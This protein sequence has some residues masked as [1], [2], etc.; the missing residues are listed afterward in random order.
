MEAISSVV[1]KHGLLQYCHA[2]DEYPVSRCAR[3]RS[4][5]EVEAELH[6]VT[7]IA[8][9]EDMGEFPWSDK[10][11]SIGVH[12]VCRLLQAHSEEEVM[13]LVVGSYLAAGT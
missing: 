11:E 4:A 3:H 7:R 12:G 8:P 10:R 5:Y 2:F 9:N 6:L 1:G 13:L